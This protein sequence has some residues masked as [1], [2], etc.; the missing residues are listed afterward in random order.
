VMTTPV[1][2]VFTTPGFAG[3]GA[4]TGITVISD[5]VSGNTS[6][7]AP[8]GMHNTCPAYQPFRCPNGYCA[9]ASADCLSAPDVVNCS[10]GTINC[11]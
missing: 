2:P 7:D 5:D 9:R 3:S 1:A 10:D 11:P 8:A 6:R 4:E